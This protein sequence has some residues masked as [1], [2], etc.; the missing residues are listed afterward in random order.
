[1]AKDAKDPLSRYFEAAM[2]LTELT[3]KRA[4]KIVKSVVKQ[5]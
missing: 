1:M 4:E 2:G 5:S 3:R